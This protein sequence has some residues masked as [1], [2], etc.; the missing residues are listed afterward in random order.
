MGHE[1]EAVRDLLFNK[2]IPEE[3]PKWGAYYCPTFINGQLMAAAAE[4]PTNPM[5]QYP[6][7]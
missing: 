7:G 6:Q 1:P 3:N 2:G 5:N 4:Y